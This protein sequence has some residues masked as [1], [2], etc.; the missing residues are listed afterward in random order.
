VLLRIK[1][2]SESFQ[3]RTTPLAIYPL[4]VLAGDDLRPDGFQA[5]GLDD[6]SHKIKKY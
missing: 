3:H 2:V 4:T 5:A 1:Q 6:I